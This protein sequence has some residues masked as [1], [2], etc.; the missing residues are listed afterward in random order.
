MKYKV[1]VI[2]KN[3]MTRELYMWCVVWLI[4]HPVFDEQMVTELDSRGSKP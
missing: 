3:Y 4:T 2:L 1:D